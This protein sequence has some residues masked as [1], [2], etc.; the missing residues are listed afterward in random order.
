MG[1]LVLLARQVL[2]IILMP[3]YTIILISRQI[4]WII[5]SADIYRILIDAD[6]QETRISF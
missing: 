6:P 3:N 1:R 5:I 4:E 2:G